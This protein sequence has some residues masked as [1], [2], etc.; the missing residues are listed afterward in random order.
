MEA[1]GQL[2]SL[3]PP[4]KSGPDSHDSGG[5]GDPFKKVFTYRIFRWHTVDNS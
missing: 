4:F 1:P 2:P 3:R 5:L